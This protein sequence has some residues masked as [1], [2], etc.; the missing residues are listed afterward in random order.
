MRVLG[1]DHSDVGYSHYNLACL[2][3][4]L[5]KR[6][7]SLTHLRN[8]VTLNWA[9]DDILTNSELDVLRGNPEFEEIVADVKKRI[10]E[11]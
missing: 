7:E 9:E 5:G 2:S 10:G 8:A 11:R 1:A 3:A 4:A 6:A